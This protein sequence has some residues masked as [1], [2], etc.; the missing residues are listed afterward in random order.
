MKWLLIVLVLAACG[1]T[2]E[3]VVEREVPCTV[4][5]VDLTTDPPTAVVSDSTCIIGG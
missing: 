2:T 3:P 4:V 5:T 1:S